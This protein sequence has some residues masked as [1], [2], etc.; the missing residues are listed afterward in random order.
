MRHS[1]YAVASKHPVALLKIHPIHPVNAYY[2]RNCIEA[3]NSGLIQTALFV[4]FVRTLALTPLQLALVGVV[5]ML[6]HV[7]LEIPTGVIAAANSRC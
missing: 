4:L 5:H 2:L 1:N 3:F 7:L 6:A